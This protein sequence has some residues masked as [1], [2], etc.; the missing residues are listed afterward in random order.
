M[1]G[2]RRT[3][4]GRP[5]A[6]NVTIAITHRG[7][8]P[9]GPAARRRGTLLIARIIKRGLSIDRGNRPSA[10]LAVRVAPMSGATTT[11]RRGSLPNPD[12]IVAQADLLLTSRPILCRGPNASPW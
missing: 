4:A 5:L 12:A 9:S 7:G 3:P 8:S 1:E 10:K 2:V 11:P 6:R